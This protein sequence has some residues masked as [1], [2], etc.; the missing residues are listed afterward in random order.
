[1]GIIE[2]LGD[3]RNSIELKLGNR[4][5]YLTL[6]QKIGEKDGYEINIRN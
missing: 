3:P 1:M 6:P 2:G 4:Y 5:F